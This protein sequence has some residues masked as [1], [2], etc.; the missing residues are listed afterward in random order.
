MGVRRGIPER[1]TGLW[2]APGRIERVETMNADK[3]HIVLMQIKTVRG[4][5]TLQFTHCSQSLGILA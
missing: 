1:E 3:M 4:L 2:P 5:T